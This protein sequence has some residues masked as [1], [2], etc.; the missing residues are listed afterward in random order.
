MFI[1]AMF[2]PSFHGALCAPLIFRCKNSSEE[3]FSPNQTTPTSSVFINLTANQSPNERHRT[4]LLAAV[5]VVLVLGVVLVTGEALLRFYGLKQ[6]F[7][8]LS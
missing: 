8:G 1:L 5:S 7:P 6:L 3:S 4:G 2:L